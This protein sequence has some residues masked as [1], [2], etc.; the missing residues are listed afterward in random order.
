MSI[1]TEDLLE[2]V[3]A[4]DHGEEC[5]IDPESSPPGPTIRVLF[6][7]P[8]LGQDQNG[9]FQNT[10]P[11]AYAKT[12]DVSSVQRES[13]VLRIL[14]RNYTVN[15]LEQVEGG[16]RWRLLMLNDGVED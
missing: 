9:T 5:E 4:T 2:L 12:S 11:E 14:G 6:S 10:K 8:F 13:T 16:N 3:L 15:R 1:E 7:A